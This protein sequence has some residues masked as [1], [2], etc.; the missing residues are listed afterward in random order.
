MEADRGPSQS[1][2]Q[3]SS[4]TPASRIA[5]LNEIDR[6]IST[7]L[8][9]ASDALGILSNSPASVSQEKALK[10]SES[11]RAAFTA[12]AE[13]YFSTLSSIEVRLRRQVYALEEAELIRPGDDKD[14][15]KGRALGGD[16]GITTAGGGPLDPS[17]LNARVS[18][19]V[20]D[21]MKRELLARA[22]E[23]VERVGRDTPDGNVEAG[24]S[25]AVQGHDNDEEMG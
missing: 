10:N 24:K 9:A 15:R 23:F 5:E 25:G 7:L 18:D 14:A 19:K 3:P 12:A 13:A 1:K 2:N 20:G 4:F 17:W 22:R 11:A 6:S 16:S 8:S 21:G